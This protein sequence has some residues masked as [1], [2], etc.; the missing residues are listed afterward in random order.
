MSS[1]MASAGMRQCS[2][3]WPTS[4][5][6]A[7]KGLVG[8]AEQR[9]PWVKGTLACKLDGEGAQH[10]SQAQGGAVHL[11]VLLSIGPHI[12]GQVVSAQR[13][14]ARRSAPRCAARLQQEGCGVQPGGEQA[15]LG[16]VQAPVPYC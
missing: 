11:P 8:G 7:A 2:G 12:L 13:L 14:Q 10:A 3:S 15:A 6:G 4:C 9:P 1:T 5:I 16:G